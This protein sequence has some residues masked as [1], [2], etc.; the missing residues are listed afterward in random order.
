MEFGL[1]INRCD[2]TKNNACITIYDNSSADTLKAMLAFNNNE[3]AI[4]AKMFYMT[5]YADFTNIKDK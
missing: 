5:Q 1:R 3:N 2:I 4:S